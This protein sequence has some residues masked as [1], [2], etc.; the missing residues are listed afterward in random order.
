[1]VVVLVANDR[2]DSGQHSC[3]GKQVAYNQLRLVVAR[4]VQAFRIMPGESFDEVKYRNQWSEYF[5]VSL[6]ELPLTFRPR[7]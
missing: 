3:V 5:I 7:D 4:L 2:G 1:M 6:G